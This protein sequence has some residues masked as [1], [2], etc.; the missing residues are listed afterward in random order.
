MIHSPTTPFHFDLTAISPIQLE[1]MADAGSR[2]RECYRVLTKG[3]LNIVGE[4]LRGQGA[5]YEFEHYPKD[6][7][8]DPDTH[9]Q[10][11]YH[12]HRADAVEHGHFHT[13]IRQPGMP[14]GVFPIAHDGQ[15]TWPSGEQA[16]THVVGVSMDAYGFPIALFTTNRWG[17]AEAWY[18][19]EDII[20][21][22]DRFHID[23]AFPSWP[24]NIWLSHLPILFRP[25][26][27]WLL[28]ERDRK[29]KQWRKAHP[30]VD[31]YE[32]RR[33][34]VISHL[35]IDVETRIREVAAALRIK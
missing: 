33:L 19:A 9:C 20:G 10:Y 30:D 11:Y 25:Q 23:H 4:V 14:E 21:M 34:E 31:V 13:F 26:V 6:D 17:T 16:L 22:L 28:R 27:E 1:R 18:R 24:V 7:V 15:E 8:F 2:I 12:A 29:V 3:G 32:D 35:P 5:F